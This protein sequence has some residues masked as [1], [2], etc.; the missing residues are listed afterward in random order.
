MGNCSISGHTCGNVYNRYSL[1]I[2]NDWPKHRNSLT[3]R[4]LEPGQNG[5]H[6]GQIIDIRC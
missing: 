3:W 5:R 2:T 6:V 4:T 1:M